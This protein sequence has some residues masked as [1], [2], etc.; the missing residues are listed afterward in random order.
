MILDEKNVKI[1]F[2]PDGTDLKRGGDELILYQQNFRLDFPD[3]IR[4]IPAA[5]ENTDL[6]N[7]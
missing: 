2:F 6:Y 1:Y 4:L 5:F 3:R 7:E